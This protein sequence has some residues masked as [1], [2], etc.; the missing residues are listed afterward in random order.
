MASKALTTLAG[1]TTGAPSTHTPSAFPTIPTTAAYTTTAS[2]DNTTTL[3]PPTEDDGFCKLILYMEIGDSR[4]RVWD[5]LLLLPTVLFLIG[6][7]IKIN[8]A[9]LK[10]RA[11][12][13]PI[14]ATFYGLIWLNTLVSVTRCVVSMTV[15]AATPIGRCSKQAVVCHRSFLFI[16][17]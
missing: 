15:N 1:P 2:P 4:V 8:S 7:L 9:R 11:V 13:S 12:H 14:Y 3:K 6:L 17:Y 5:L 10:L 16:S